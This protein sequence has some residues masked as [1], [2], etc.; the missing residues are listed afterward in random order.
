MEQKHFSSL[1]PLD[2]VQ[3]L[4]DFNNVCGLYSRYYGKR[5][6]NAGNWS[7]QQWT[8]VIN[9]IKTR[10]M[11]TYQKEFIFSKVQFYVAIY[12][13]TERKEGELKMMYHLN[14]ISKP[15][16]YN[17][18]FL[19]KEPSGDKVRDVGVD[20]QIATD[21]LHGALH[22]QFEYCILMSDDRDFRPAIKVIHQNTAQRIIHC[23]FQTSLQD[24]SFDH[25]DMKDFF[26]HNLTQFKNAN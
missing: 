21:M 12:P 19:E 23:G 2:R 8:L 18:H 17:F 14:N 5:D 7:P 24:I 1:E 11:A 6:R 9:W 22:N 13:E 16:G 4:V 20:V 3:I 25:I 10:C 15:A 26:N